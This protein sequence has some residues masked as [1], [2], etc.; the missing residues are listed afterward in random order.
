MKTIMFI[1]NGDYKNQNPYWTVR[2]WTDGVAK[3]EIIGPQTEYTIMQSF[4]KNLPASIVAE[5][6]SLPD[7]LIG[8]DVTSKPDGNQVIVHFKE[9]G[10]ATGVFL[11][12]DVKIESPYRRALENTVEN[13]TK[14]FTEQ[15]DGQIS[16]EGAPS[17]ELSS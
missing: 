3:G 11:I 4:E 6:F 8:H 1:H 16:S 15:N 5:V 9:N 13:L 2:L 17:N 10:Y 12:S 7:D 14:E